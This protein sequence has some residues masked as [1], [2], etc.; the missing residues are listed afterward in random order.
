MLYL[1]RRSIIK[2][3]Y[4]RF[5][6]QNLDAIR[7]HEMNDYYLMEINIDHLFKPSQHK[8]NSVQLKLKD[9]IR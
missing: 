1:S 9:E 4:L 8:L 7:I 6:L 5:R 2:L 3:V